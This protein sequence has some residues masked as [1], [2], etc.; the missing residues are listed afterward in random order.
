MCRCVETTPIGVQVWLGTRSAQEAHIRQG[1]RRAWEPCICDAYCR[2]Y[3]QRCDNYEQCGRVQGVVPALDL[4]R[5]PK[6]G[7]VC[8]VDACRCHRFRAGLGRRLPGAER[9]SSRVRRPRTDAQA[10]SAVS[11]LHN[12]PSPPLSSACL[13][14]MRTQLAPSTKP[15]FGGGTIKYG[16]RSVA[17]CSVPVISRTGSHPGR[18]PTETIS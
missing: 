1:P 18:L 13:L 16:C 6:C 3:R 12:P 4:E 11:P 8:F 14:S 15:R 17:T 2:E 9:S 7:I 5:K 10:A